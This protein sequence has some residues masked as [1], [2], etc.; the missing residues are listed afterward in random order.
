[1][2]CVPVIFFAALTVISFASVLTLKF[3]IRSPSALSSLASSL[4]AP[5]AF[6]LTVN[7]LMP[8]EKSTLFATAYPPFWMLTACLLGVT[9]ALLSSADAS[10]STFS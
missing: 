7:S 9:I 8:F 10:A 6:A 4:F 3:A 1:M 2:S 5:L